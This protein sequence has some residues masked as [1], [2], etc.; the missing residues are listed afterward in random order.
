[1]GGGVRRKFQ[2]FFDRPLLTLVAAVAGGVVGFVAGFAG[3]SRTFGAAPVAVGTGAG[4]L[5]VVVLWYWARLLRQVD[6][7]APVHE[8]QVE[9]D[10]YENA[11]AAI[12]NRGSRLVLHHSA[13]ITYEMGAT[14]DLDQITESY[15]TSEGKAD[16]PLLWY[17]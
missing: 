10:K 17:E 11:L 9:R 1:M 13:V 2:R 14:R 7:L 3:L 12:A 15:V 4:I 16:H 6:V 8:L 5:L